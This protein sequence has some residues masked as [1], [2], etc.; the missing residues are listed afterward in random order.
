M[1]QKM[2]RRA[3]PCPAAVAV[4]LAALFT[5]CAGVAPTTTDVDTLLRAPQLSGQASAVQRALNSYLGQTATLKYP[6]SGDFLSP[7]LFGD[8]DG[9]GTQ[10]AAALYAGEGSG[11]NVCLAVLEPSGDTTWQVTQVAEGLSS[12]VESVTYAPLRDEHSEEILV[13]YGGAQNDRYLAVYTYADGQ[14][15]TVIKQAYTEM[16]LANITGQGNTQDLVLALPTEEDNAGI[17]LQ[18]LTSVDGTFKSGQSLSIGA[19]QYSGCAALHAGTG[20]DGAAY[21]VVDGWSGG[22]GN[23]LSTT[24]MVYDGENF[25][26]VYEPEGVWDFHRATTR[27]DSALLSRDIDGNGTV[28]IPTEVDDGGTLDTPMDKR[29]QFLLWKDYTDAGGGNTEFGIYDSEYQF[30]LPLPESL[31]GNVRLK[32]NAAGTGWMICNA[33]DNTI[34]CE[35]RVVDQK[36]SQNGDYQRITNL[37][38]QQ[39]QAR[40]ATTRPYYGLSVED[41]VKNIVFLNS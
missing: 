12:E 30:F 17:D 6:A 10:E 20:R 32:A 31:H 28:D 41:I 16:L 35:L 18:L 7:F 25:L 38:N 36:Q 5:G 23:N 33:E 40:V 26:T 1:Q 37:G 2:L 22:T 39:L 27:Y 9:D 8:W 13:G 24:I 11:A 34:Y 19:G 29:L 3:A 15:H 14:L 21:L 4:A